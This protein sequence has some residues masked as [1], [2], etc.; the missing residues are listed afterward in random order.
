[1]EA[2]HHCSWRLAACGA[3]CGAGTQ[4]LRGAALVVQVDAIQRE[5]FGIGG[6]QLTLAPLD[7]LRGQTREEKVCSSSELS[8]SGHSKQLDCAGSF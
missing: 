7:S 4:A 1:M 2:V 5:E 6:S 3:A 8:A